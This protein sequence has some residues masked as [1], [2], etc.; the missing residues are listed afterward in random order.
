MTEKARRTI[1]YAQTV[2]MDDKLMMTGGPNRR[3]RVSK[4]IYARLHAAVSVR[5]RCAVDRLTPTVRT[6]IIHHTHR[7]R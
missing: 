7:S 6:T 2:S 4:R 1:V 5:Q 3:W